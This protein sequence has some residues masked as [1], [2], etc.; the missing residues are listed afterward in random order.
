M[1]KEKRF[2][3]YDIDKKSELD[4]RSVLLAFG[5]VLLLV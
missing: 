2:T 3:G 4:I 5:A 1:K